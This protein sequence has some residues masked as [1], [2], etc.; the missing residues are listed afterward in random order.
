MKFR[1][2]FHVRGWLEKIWSSHAG[3]GKI[4]YGGVIVKSDYKQN[5]YVS[6]LE[7]V[8]GLFIPFKA[9]LEREAKLISMRQL[10]KHLQFIAYRVSALL[11]FIPNCSQGVNIRVMPRNNQN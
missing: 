10:P 8:F 2:D 4:A 6:F 9:V 11:N 7:C 1:T 3:L 5:S